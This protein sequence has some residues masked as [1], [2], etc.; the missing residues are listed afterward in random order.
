[1]IMVYELDR[2]GLLQKCGIG[3]VGLTRLLAL[4]VDIPLDLR[5]FLSNVLL[6]FLGYKITF[7][8]RV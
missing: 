7:K 8:F 4:N 3:N 6:N 5:I 1:V 2:P